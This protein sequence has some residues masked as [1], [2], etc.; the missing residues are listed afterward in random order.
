[1]T[2]TRLAAVTAVML[3]TQ[4]AEAQVSASWQVFTT[5]DSVEGNLNSL[6][7]TGVLQGDSAPTTQNLVFSGTE[8]VAAAAACERK[9]LL[10]MSKPGQYLFSALW[11]S[12]GSCSC[13]LTRVGP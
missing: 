7:V 13:K 11:A 10:A 5:V 9:A 1:M 8:S 4:A 2:L 12:A 3:F 6:K